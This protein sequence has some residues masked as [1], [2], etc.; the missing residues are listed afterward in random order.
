MK[1]VKI[2]SISLKP[3]MNYAAYTAQDFL[4]DEDFQNWVLQPGPEN[5]LFWENWLR[6]HPRQQ[7]AVNQARQAL[8]ALDLPPRRLSGEQV[9]SM[10][11]HLQEHVHQT[12][13]PAAK[14][15]QEKNRIF[16]GWYQAA[17]VFLGLALT[18]LALWQLRAPGQ[19]LVSVQ[20][21]FGQT[22]R[23][24]LPDQSVAVLNGNSVLRYASRWPGD[25]T[26]RVELQGEAYFEVR[27]T[28]KNQGFLVSFSDSVRVEVLGTRFLVT[29]RARK[30][31]VVLQQG[32]VALALRRPAGEARAL[33]LP[34]D[35]VEVR[36]QGLQQGK[37]ANP[38]AFL[39]FLQDKLVFHNT[40]LSEVAR[41]LE[42]NYG[43]KV[44]FADPSLAAR[45]FTGTGHP[46]KL[47]LLLTAIEKSFGL[48][49]TRK[50]KNLMVRQR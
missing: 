32:R 46:A 47:P 18:A 42:D 22:R 39:A 14:G 36:R 44:R 29:S 8:L 2:L 33:M 41:V 23:V 31:R 24:T 5:S 35:L 50:G 28:E 1:T 48:K 17:A 19:D 6:Q 11:D 9:Q 12:R 15:T 45:R 26:R 37:T 34:G 13:L 16:R 3:P 40:P 7:G 30:A 25:S 10:W 21:G 38:E 4:Q 49:I 20:T 43:Y 27:H